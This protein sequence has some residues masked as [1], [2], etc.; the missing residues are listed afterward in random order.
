VCAK[1]FTRQGT[2]NTTDPCVANTD[3]VPS[4]SA[5]VIQ[6]TMDYQA[7]LPCPLQGT[8]PTTQKPALD[9]LS[10][11]RNTFTQQNLLPDITH[12]LMASWRKGTQNQYKTY[13][14][15]WLAFCGER[16][17]DHSS[18][19]ISEA[20]QFLMYLYNQGL[21]YSMINT[22]RSALSSVL[23]LSSPGYPV[24]KGNMRHRNHNRNTKQFMLMLQ[25]LN[26]SRP[27]GH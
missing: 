10:F 19:Q 2:G 8:T 9:G 6:P 4:C 7:T 3:M 18:P 16:K 12:I 21:S 13:V 17:I 14:E 24:F 15:K 1:N 20:L 22:A 25:Y 26:T 27:Y 5:T 23:W 11:I